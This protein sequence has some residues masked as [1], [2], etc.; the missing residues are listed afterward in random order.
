MDHRNTVDDV[1]T[2]EEKQN[3]AAEYTL[4]QVGINAY[5]EKFR[6]TTI[7]ERGDQTR[8]ADIM[9]SLKFFLV[10]VGVVALV[11]IAV[12]AMPH[13]GDLLEGILNLL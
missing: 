1:L 6:F 5:H 8:S 13:I 3:D 9:H 2:E 10:V 7:N 11:A 12:Y 4:K